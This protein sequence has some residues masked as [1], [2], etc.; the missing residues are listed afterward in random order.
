VS[1]DRSLVRPGDSAARSTSGTNTDG[2]LRHDRT[3]T[4][5]GGEG[6]PSDAAIN[7]W[8]YA[9]DRQTV[10]FWAGTGRDFRDGV[11]AASWELSCWLAAATQRDVDAR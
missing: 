2:E 11:G 7:V 9:T 8:C 10:T 4:F 5:G 3:A 1:E 6:S